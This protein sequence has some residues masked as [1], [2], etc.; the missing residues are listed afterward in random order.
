MIVLWSRHF[1]VEQKHGQQTFTLTIIPEEPTAL[2]TLERD[3]VLSG[4][5]LLVTS[6]PAQRQ[7]Q[8]TY[9]TETDLKS[10]LLL[11]ICWSD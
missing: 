11:I 4:V 1:I 8:C 6:R 2:H 5:C 10:V 3:T 9:C 7:Q